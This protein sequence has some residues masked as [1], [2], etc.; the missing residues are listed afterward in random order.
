MSP[1]QTHL[2]GFAVGVEDD[3]CVAGGG[4]GPGEARPDQAELP[5]L[6]V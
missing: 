2:S 4:L 3:D 1:I 6:D 5:R